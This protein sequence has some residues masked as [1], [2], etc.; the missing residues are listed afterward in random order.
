MNKR[1][2]DKFVKKWMAYIGVG[3]LSDGD[4]LRAAA[5][6]DLR[7]LTV[8]KWI[9]KW[10]QWYQPPKFPVDFLQEIRNE[11]VDLKI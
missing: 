11:L 7:R 1:D 3:N 8:K 2:R 6:R 5:T 9:A 10:G 4:D